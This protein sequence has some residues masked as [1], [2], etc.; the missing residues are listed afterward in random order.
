VEKRTDDDDDND[1]DDNDDGVRE[2]LKDAAWEVRKIEQIGG[3]LSLKLSCGNMEVTLFFLINSCMIRI[4]I[5]FNY[6][7]R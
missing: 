6:Q 2:A 7:T 5:D 4:I 3:F 1:D